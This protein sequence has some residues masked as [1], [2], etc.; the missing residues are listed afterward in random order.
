MAEEYTPCGLLRIPD[1][2]MR[3]VVEF[4]TKSLRAILS[5]QLINQHFH[6]LM[7]QPRMLSHVRARFN[8]FLD[9]QH[10]GSGLRH[11]SI[12]SSRST[13]APLAL[14][15]DLRTLH[16]PRWRI[17]ADVM[18]HL[19]NLTKLE[20]LDLSKSTWL[21]KLERLPASLKR[22]NIAETSVQELPFLPGLEELDVSCCREFTASQEFDAPDFIACCPNLRSL[23]MASSK[24]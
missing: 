10:L 17:N 4:A 14:L 12:P 3:T 19:K 24:W 8:D 16:M 7:R 5:L 9:G 18:Q 21:T 2:V 22:L 15:R 1:D 20:E 6:I 11:L 13:L 23:T